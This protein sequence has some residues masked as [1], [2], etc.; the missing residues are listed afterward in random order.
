VI[1]A[2]TGTLLLF[3]AVKGAMSPVPL[4]GRPIE[5]MLFTQL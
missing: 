1:V 5:L 2:V 4:S 3:K